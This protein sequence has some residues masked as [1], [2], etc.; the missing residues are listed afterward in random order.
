M[1]LAIVK[2]LT[3]VFAWAKWE[4]VSLWHVMLTLGTGEPHAI[5]LLTSLA[6]SGIL[7]QRADLQRVSVGNGDL[8][9]GLC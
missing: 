6:A 8:G 5:V 3:L 9:S 4:D 7:P 1:A 2:K